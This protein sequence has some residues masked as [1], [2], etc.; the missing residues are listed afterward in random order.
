M[1]RISAF[2]GGVLGLTIFWWTPTIVDSFGLPPSDPALDLF[3]TDAHTFMLMVVLAV[4][5]YVLP[6]SLIF[7]RTGRKGKARLSLP[8]RNTTP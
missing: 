8:E 7:T 3:S 2:C 4:V 5:L 6:L 1:K